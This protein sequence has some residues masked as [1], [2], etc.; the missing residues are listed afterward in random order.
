M[1]FGSLYISSIIVETTAAEY[2]VVTFG[3]STSSFYY[4]IIIGLNVTT[5]NFVANVSTVM[6]ELQEDP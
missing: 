1:Y 2:V 3:T 5:T 4:P 6:T